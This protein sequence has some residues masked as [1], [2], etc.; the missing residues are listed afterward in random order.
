M[1]RAVKD[2]RSDQNVTA[3]EVEYSSKDAVK[4]KLEPHV[5]IKA[6]VYFQA[7]WLKSR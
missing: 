3:R 7:F 2:L 4:L 6:Y 5:A 1:Q